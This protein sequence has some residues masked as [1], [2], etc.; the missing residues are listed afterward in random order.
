MHPS[1]ESQSQTVTI[2]STQISI[3]RFDG[4]LGDLCWKSVSKV[5]LSISDWAGTF[6]VQVT[7]GSI[8]A[9]L[10]GFAGSD[11]KK[12]HQPTENLVEIIAMILLPVAVI[13]VAY[14]LMVFIWRSKAIAKKQVQPLKSGCTRVETCQETSWTE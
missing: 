1:L 6:G 5:T 11:S 9:A 10:L 12:E 4:C 13:M 2:A 7:I 14:A 8:A 3:F